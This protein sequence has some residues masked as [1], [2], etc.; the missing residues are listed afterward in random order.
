M[1]ENRLFLSGEE[2]E[3]YP[4]S[5]CRSGSPSKVNHFHRVTSCPCLPR[6]V[7]VHFRVRQLSCLQNDKRMKKMTERS[8]NIR[9][10]GGSVHDECCKGDAS[11]QWE[12]A[13]LPLSPHPHPLPES[14]AH[15]ILHT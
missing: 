10:I 13:N 3:S 2:N 5:T 9:L 1:S 11:S 15:E 4:E 6:L 12:K 7:E 8:H 14:H